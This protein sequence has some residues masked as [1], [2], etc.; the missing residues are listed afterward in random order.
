[1]K[2]REKIGRLF[3]CDHCRRGVAE[4]DKEIT[5]LEKEVAFWKNIALKFKQKYQ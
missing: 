2:I 1:M 4:R 5:N 3:P